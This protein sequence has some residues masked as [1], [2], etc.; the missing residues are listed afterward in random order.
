[1]MLVGEISPYPT[2]VSV[3]RDQYNDLLGLHR[4]CRVS[5]GMVAKKTPTNR[6]A[7]HYAT[8]V[9]YFSWKDT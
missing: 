3:V 6:F 8:H 2:V 1:M 7:D 4:K 5:V 9:V